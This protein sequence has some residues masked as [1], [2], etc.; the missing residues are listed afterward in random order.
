MSVAGKLEL[1][2]DY[3]SCF[4]QWTQLPQMLQHPAQDQLVVIEY[5]YH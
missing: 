2:L 4:D 3:Q 5:L 1:L